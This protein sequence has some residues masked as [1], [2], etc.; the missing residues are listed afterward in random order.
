[1]Y[2]VYQEYYQR[3]KNS[4]AFSKYCKKVFGIDLSQDGFC[5]KNSLDIMIEKMNL[6]KD[7]ICLDIG[8]GNGG[9]ADYISR[10]AGAKIFG[11]DYSENAISSAKE[12]SNRALSF[13][14]AD[15]NNLS[16]D[17]NRFSI[18]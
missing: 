8:C 18:I 10:K 5:N 2:D 11:I 12:K 6:S 1:M 4:A 3:V 13:A 14:V 7:D 9:I 17:K 15:I 16:I